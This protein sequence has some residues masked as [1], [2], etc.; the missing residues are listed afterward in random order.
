MVSVTLH[1][2]TQ[3]DRDDFMGSLS[4]GWGEE[5]CDLSWDPEVPFEDVTEFGVTVLDEIWDA[6]AMEWK[7]REI[8]E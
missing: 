2:K 4:D 6:D 3:Q 5:H 1:F 7:D 8:E